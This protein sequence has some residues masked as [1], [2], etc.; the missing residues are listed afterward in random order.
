MAEIR[1]RI[2]VF[3]AKHGWEMLGRGRK[4]H[5]SIYGEVNGLSGVIDI[6]MVFECWDT[7]PEHLDDSTPFTVF[8]CVFNDTAEGR[9]ADSKKFHMETTYGEV[10]EN[11][12]E[13]LAETWRHVSS[14]TEKDTVMGPHPLG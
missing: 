13:F 8:A 14:R 12:D 11:L 2:S 4:A 5:A 3:G 7:C 9:Y 1:E 10:G 6:E